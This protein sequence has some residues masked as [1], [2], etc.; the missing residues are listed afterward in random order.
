[1]LT[2]SRIQSDCV[3]VQKMDKVPQDKYQNK[4]NA[5]VYVKQ[6]GSQMRW[7]QFEKQIFR[8]YRYVFSALILFATLKCVKFYKE[9]NIVTLTT[10]T[11]VSNYPCAKIKSV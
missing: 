3:I 10:R 9:I 1:M 6:K 7:K 5:A 4:W 8:F 11:W 2:T